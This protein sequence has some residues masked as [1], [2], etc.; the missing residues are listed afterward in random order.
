MTIEPGRVIRLMLV[1]VG[2]TVNLDVAG[3][4]PVTRYTTTAALETVD[5][6][7]PCELTIGGTNTFWTSAQLN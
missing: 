4:T 3:G 2:T 1:G 5:I 6:V 7:G